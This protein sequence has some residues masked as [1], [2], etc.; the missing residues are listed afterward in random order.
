MM[1][2]AKSRSTHPTYPSLHRDSTLR[3]LGR[4]KQ[5]ILGLVIRQRLAQV[6]QH[7]DAALD[8]RAFGNFIELALGMRI[9]GPVDSLIL[10]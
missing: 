6:G 5:H 10:P 9:V 7:F 1:G 8:C 4:A 3:I 2:Y